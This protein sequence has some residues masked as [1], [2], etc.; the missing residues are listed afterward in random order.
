MMGAD[1]VFVIYGGLIGYPSDDINKFLWM[2]RIAGGVYPEIKE[3][4]FT[5]MAGYR[6]DQ[7]VA[8]ALASS[9]MYK[10]TYYNLT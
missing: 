7:N 10:L 1:Y 2:V 4:D 3:K 5:G 8:P 6:V 9:L